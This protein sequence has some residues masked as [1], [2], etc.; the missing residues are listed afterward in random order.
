[1]CTERGGQTEAAELSPE[2]TEKLLCILSWR[3]PDQTGI[4]QGPV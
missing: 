4:F 3:W 2:S 1:M